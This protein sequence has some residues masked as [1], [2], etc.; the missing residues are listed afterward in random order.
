MTDYLDA[1]LHG[2]TAQKRQRAMQQTV[3]GPASPA[4][5]GRASAFWREAPL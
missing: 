4:R 5:S 2:K 1:L 3:T